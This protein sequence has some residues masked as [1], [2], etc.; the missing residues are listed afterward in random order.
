MVKQWKKKPLVIEALQWTGKNIDE[1]RAFCSTAVFN[2]PT[3]VST[4]YDLEIPTLEGNHVATVGDY[5]ILR[6]VRHRP[7]G[8]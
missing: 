8:R 5:I 3:H 4:M 7:L 2:I 1:V 6:A